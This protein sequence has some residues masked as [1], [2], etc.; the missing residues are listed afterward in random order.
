MPEGRSAAPAPAVYHAYAKI[1]LYLAVIDRRPDG[2]HDIETLFQ[3]VGL[4]DEVRLTPG[5]GAITLSCNVPEL[6]SGDNL[7][8]RAGRLLQARHAPGR[9][10]HIAI[11]KRIPVAAG[12]AGGSSDAAA[13]LVGLNELWGVGLSIEALQALGAEIGSDV[14]FLIRGGTMSGTGRGDVLQP[15]DPLRE[16][17]FVLLHPAIEVSAGR[18]Y[19]HPEL[20]KS[21]EERIGGITSSFEG[22]LA[23][24][25][26]GSIMDVLYNAM[27]IPV[28]M[29]YPEV[30]VLKQ[31]LLDAGCAGAM[32]SGSGPT[33]F[34]LCK[35][36]AHAERIAAQ[37]TG[38]ASS[39]VST[40][41]AGSKRVA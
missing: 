23:A 5:G 27:E 19:N 35:D 16:I 31:R 32:M 38:V 12:L 4:A 37:F 10:A 18:V 2:F 15:L 21:R 6:E 25:S 13:A 24:V 11:E 20:R 22:V 40:V 8:G 34:G 30:A 1:N 33:L 39:V 29:E 9:G 3:T 7:A 41:P 26:R 17:W 14:P 28:F 36:R